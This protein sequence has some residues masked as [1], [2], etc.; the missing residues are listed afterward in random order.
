MHELEIKLRQKNFIPTAEIIKK[1]YNNRKI[2]LYGDSVPLRRLLKDSYGIEVAHV[3]TAVEA[4]V[5]NT[6]KNI[7]DFFGKSDE[8]YIA[9]PFLAPEEKHKIFLDSMGYKEFRDYVFSLHKRIESDKGFKNYHD[10]YGNDINAPEGLRVVIAPSAGNVK[11]NIA[12]NA[13]FESRSVLSA[14]GSN[15]EITIEKNC[16]F[17][18]NMSFTAYDN[19]KTFIGSGCSFEREF[20]IRICCGSE[21]H[22]GA[23]CMFSSYIKMYCGD[24]HAIFD[25]GT[26]ERTLDII[27][28]NSRNNIIIGDHV[29][30]GLNAMI[31]GNTNIGRSSIIGAGAVVKGRFPNN[32]AAAGNPAKIIKKNVTW[33]K[34]YFEMDIKNCGK[35][36]IALTGL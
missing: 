6:R 26:G 19:S 30:V 3:A 20:F 22:I 8:Y 29:W 35:E 33:T 13:R 36:N 17:S 5:D 23:D 25:V 7:R 11:I 34:N 18:T 28:R 1:N 14:E 9:V 4:N 12:E 16:F 24:G 32:C 27:N 10:E 2:V 15:A 21:V 31:L